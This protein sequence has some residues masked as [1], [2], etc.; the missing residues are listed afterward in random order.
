MTFSKLAMQE[1][2]FKFLSLYQKSITQLYGI[3]DTWTEDEAIKDSPIWN[4]IN[5][6]YDYGV[7]G[8]PTGEL[9]PGANV[10]FQYAT[11]E[12]FLLG[13]DTPQM[14]LYLL[15]N[16]NSPPKLAILAM[17]S[18][19][20]RL[21]LDNGWRSTDYGEGDMNHLSIA[22][23]ALLANMD[24]RSVRN[25]ANPRLPD[26]LKTEQIGKRSLISIE[27]A[28]LWLS[29]RKSFI[30]TKECEESNVRRLPQ[31]NF[32]A[33]ELLAKLGN[34]ENKLLEFIERASKFG[35]SLDNLKILLE[36]KAK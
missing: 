32:D 5:E 16:N 1:E 35:L 24:E 22:E 4:A 7:M 34:D 28:K 21:V 10:H 3:T 2:L 11:V 23:V 9:Y 25:A 19:I 26:R 33:T 13:V 20:A 27:N 18:A 30:P 15:E 6:M 31:L 17:R 29:G 8:I 36:G 14:K 12:K